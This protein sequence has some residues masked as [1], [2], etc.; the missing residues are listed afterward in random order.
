[1]IKGSYDSKGGSLKAHGILCSV[2]VT[3]ATLNETSEKNFCQ[4]VQKHC[5]E[6]KRKKNGCC[7]AFYV[8]RENSNGVFD[9]FE[10]N[11]KRQ[12]HKMV[13]HAQTIRQLLADKLFERV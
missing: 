2:L 3:R 12:P 13:K 1:M 11:V 4:A 7:R 5:R 10:K 8:T 6:G 9:L